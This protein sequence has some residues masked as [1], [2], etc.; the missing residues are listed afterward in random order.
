M[1]PQLVPVGWGNVVHAAPSAFDS[2]RETELAPTLDQGRQ[3][4]LMARGASGVVLE[5][6]Q[7][8]LSRRRVRFTSSSDGMFGAEK[9]SE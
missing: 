5:A 8:L 3:E 7:L 6:Q 9:H 2:T 4:Q 1:H